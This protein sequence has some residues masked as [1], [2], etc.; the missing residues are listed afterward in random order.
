MKFIHVVKLFQLISIW[1]IFIQVT[2][3]CSFAKFFFNGSISIQFNF[4]FF[5]LTFSAVFNFL[6]MYSLVIGDRQLYISL[7]SKL[8]N[9]EF[10]Y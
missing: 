1:I 9:L 5:Y 7:E 10:G 3:L 8:I 4:H 2:L 6:P